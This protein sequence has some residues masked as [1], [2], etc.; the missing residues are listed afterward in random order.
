V[1]IT[2]DDLQWADADSFLLLRE[3]LRG[4][5]GP[6]VLVLGTVRGDA[7]T[8]DRVAAQLEGLMVH[9][10]TLGPLNV[11]EIR[12]LAARLVPDTS[13]LD[14]ERIA[15]EAGGHPMFLQEILRHLDASGA[16]APSATLDDA[17]LAR[18]AQLQAEARN[19]LEVVCIA[20]A[21]ISLDVAALATRLEPTAVARAAAALR[22]GS[23]AREV[24]RGRVLALEPYHDRVREAVGGRLA[25][26][27]RR[28]L[29]A[30]VAGAAET[31][32][33]Q[34]DPELLLRNFVLAGMPERG[35]RY[36]ETAAERAETAHAFEQAAELWR[37][38]LGLVP[39][40]RDD[41]RRLQ[42]RLGQ[43]LINAGRGAEA[44]EHY[45]AAAVDADRLTR[46]ECHRHAAEQLIISGRIEPGMAA[47]EEL[48]A[49]IG[50]TA[51]RTPRAALL[52]LIRHRILLRLR[53]LGFKE[54]SRR[55]IADA[56]LLVL[57]VLKVAAH[58]LALV[59]SIRGMDFQTRQLLLALRS[60]YR[61][62]IARALMLESM[63]QST[64]S[65]P[66]RA[67]KLLDRALELADQ[68]DPYM[69]AM[70]HGTI[71]M[72]AYF[73][74]DVVACVHHL[75][76][77]EMHMR[78]APGHNWEFATALLFQ[79]FG[80]RFIGDYV[81][82]RRRYDKYAVEA[83][84][85]GDR[86][87]DS[88][89]RRACVSMFLAEDDVPGAIR[90]IE[91][92]TWVAPTT[93]FHVQ[94]FHEL[95]AWG[96][97]A[98]YSGHRDERARFDENFEKLDRAMLVRVESMRVQNHYL[99]GRLALA[100]H[101]TPTDVQRHARAL[102][103]D[104]HNGLART[105]SVLLRGALAAQENR[106]DQAIALL[107]QAATTAEAAGMRLT[108]AAARRRIAELRDSDDDDALAATGE[109]GELG[110]R[111]PAKVTEMLI[112]SLRRWT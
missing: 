63:F 66:R 56:E 103:R 7:E 20:G 42:L 101:G 30:R 59:E 76:E 90:E 35:A 83:A 6:P 69:R 15:R 96:E 89:M 111:V 58:S 85:R 11:D 46:L 62:A 28:A 71:G 8:A 18:V 81:A 24:Q 77:S 9:R 106:R 39:R 16:G 109:M 79:L 40:G 50:V 49:E 45:L 91:R 12:V 104:K 108:S 26:E 31:S 5:Q 21:P 70:I 78:E 43:S 60:G 102:A 94:H 41:Q 86:Y 51:P 72:K 48:L 61:P 88:S 54:R 52:S 112:P 87:L 65:H 22:V 67:Q 1:V 73:G 92:A 99:R 14:L 95:I 110:V 29:H 17:L 10:T 36:A 32:G 74:G 37:T 64:N 25:D 100:G 34:R 68:S 4:H 53:G 23:L 44:A 38:A 27:D 55:E 84:H 97:I 3:L 47:L 33:D 75:T 2:I 80:L 107:G 19:L 57:D 105:W 13:R 93:G 82:M 98:L